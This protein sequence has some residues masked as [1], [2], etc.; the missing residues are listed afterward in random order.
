MF[1]I[2]IFLLTLREMKGGVSGTIMDLPYFSIH[3][4]GVNIFILTFIS[5]ASLGNGV[6][7]TYMKDLTQKK[8]FNPP[9]FQ[10][11]IS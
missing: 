9:N 8:L 3:S 1:L 2:K 7:N 10:I 11:V 4:S 6:G 5:S